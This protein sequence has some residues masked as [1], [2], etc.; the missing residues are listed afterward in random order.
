MIRSVVVQAPAKLNLDLRILGQRSDGYH[1]LRT[2][3]QSISLHDT[4]RLARRPGPMTVTSRMQAVPRDEAN[5][6]WGAA[7][8]LWDS[9]GYRGEP[10]GVA[11]A[12]TK[13]IPL[14]GGL[15]GGSSDAASAM[16]GLCLLWDLSPSMKRLQE[17]AATV[18]ADVPYFLT[19][20]LALGTGRG[21][22]L[23]RVAD[24]ESH[25]V[26]LAVPGFG[27][28]TASAY[29]WFDQDSRDDRIPTA[30]LP[31]GWRSQLDV[32]RNDLQAT[33]VI[34]YPGVGAMVDRL[35][36]TGAVHAAMTGS[37]STVFALYRHK[38]DAVAARRAVRLPGW[39]TILSWTVGSVEFG[40]LS[41]AGPRRS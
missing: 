35:R 9:V 3:F 39:R 27:V 33:V 31:R 38:A 10:E 24:L 19:G 29:G 23:R 26:V 2:L 6:V 15:G 30:G 20:G 37:G 14:A 34:R 25:W 8:T 1:E 32:L 4:L 17:L 13:R 12:I 7:K 18:G 40:R 22:R 16:R 36:E 41:T 11:V 5:L 28:D 21:I